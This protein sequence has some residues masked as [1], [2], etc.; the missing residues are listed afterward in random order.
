MTGDSRPELHGPALLGAALD[1]AARAHDGQVD[2][3]G[4]DYLAHPL[5]VAARVV[6][7]GW[8]AVAVALLH[9]VVEDSDVGVEDL[10]AAGFPAP[11]AEAVDHLTRRDGESH[12]DAVRRAAA[13]PLAALVKRADV[14]DNADPARLAL[15][16]QEVR[17]RLIARYERAVTLLDAAGAPA[18][19]PASPPAAP[20]A[21]PPASPPASPTT[22]P[23]A[24]PPAS[25]TGTSGAP[26]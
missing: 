25:P 10:V 7:A 12:A 6:D 15:L 24:A 13:D 3:A 23:P 9:D 22:S 14:A 16:P 11:V 19:P 5:R 26:R 18:A 21:A 4:H 17:T 2:K 8:E 1:L 20:P